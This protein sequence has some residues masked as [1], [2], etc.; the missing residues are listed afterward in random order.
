MFWVYLYL[1]VYIIFDIVLLA[2]VAEQ[3]ICRI[4]NIAPEV[5]SSIRLRDA[6]SAVIRSEM[7]D[8]KTILDIGSGWGGM[9]KHIAREFPKAKVSGI[10]LM[11]LPFVFS[12]VGGGFSRR[13]K[14]IYGNAFKWL[15]KFGDRRFDVGITYL[16]SPEMGDVEKFLSRFRVL[17][18]LDFPL[19]GVQPAKK[20]KLHKNIMGQHYIY[21][22]K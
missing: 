2:Y 9:A 1:V 17:V 12:W 13:V 14:F 18:V 3:V 7:P 20:I 4:K 22:Y 6:V 19:P 5:P 21:I 16:L 8:A 11:T 15:A 10:E